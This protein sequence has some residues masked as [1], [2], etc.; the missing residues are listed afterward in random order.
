MMLTIHFHQIFSH[1]K[2]GVDINKYE[3][4][5]RN[6]ESLVHNEPMFKQ[7]MITQYTPYSFNTSYTLSVNTKDIR[8]VG[9]T[10]HKEDILNAIRAAVGKQ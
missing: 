3:D 6:F 10:E 8:A 4:G 1:Y 2:Y 9:H 7:L 5:V